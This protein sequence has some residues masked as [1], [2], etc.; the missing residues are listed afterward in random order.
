[1]CWWYGITIK[2]RYKV[3]QSASLYTH[4]SASIEARRG[5]HLCLDALELEMSLRPVLWTI[6]HTSSRAAAVTFPVFTSVPNYTAQ[7]QS[8]AYKQTRDLDAYQ[9]CHQA[10]RYNKDYVIHKLRFSVIKI[11]RSI[12]SASTFNVLTKIFN[13]I[14]RKLRT[15]SS[16]FYLISET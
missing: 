15:V 1:V 16:Q 14:D 8:E 11:S 13:I 3:P 5:V 10:T 6:D 7:W 2:V 4:S 12:T 9:L